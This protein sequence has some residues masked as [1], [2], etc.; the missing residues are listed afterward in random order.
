MDG[1]DDHLRATVAAPKR[2]GRFVSEWLARATQAE[3]VLVKLRA[4]DPKTFDRVDASA[5]VSIALSAIFL[6]Q[7]SLQEPEIAI[8]MTDSDAE[9]FALL[10]VLGFFEEQSGKYR[11]VLPDSLKMCDVRRAVVALA[12]TEDVRCMLHPSRLLA[13]QNVE[14]SHLARPQTGRSS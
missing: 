10:S 5:I 12:G 13:C 3:E 8:H 2:D 11:F 14:A 9:D 7:R 6:L 4:Q 1:A